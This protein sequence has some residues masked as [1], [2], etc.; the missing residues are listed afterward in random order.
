M[1]TR[2]KRI[3]N[4]ENHVPWL[5]GESLFIAVNEYRSHGPGGKGG[6]RQKIICSIFLEGKLFFTIVLAHEGEIFSD[7]IADDELHFAAFTD[8]AIGDGNAHGLSIVVLAWKQDRL[9]WGQ[10][11]GCECVSAQVIGNI[12]NV[13]ALIRGDDILPW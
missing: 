4:P 10:K 11:L 9:Y 3:K 2:L 6:D 1:S 12:H 8:R 13:I 7:R 5:S